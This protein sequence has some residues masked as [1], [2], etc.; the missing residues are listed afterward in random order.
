MKIKNK[1]KKVIKATGMP[2]HQ[3]TQLTDRQ[4]RAIFIDRK[5]TM[6]QLA[7]HY[8]VS[9]T[10]IS[11]I[12]N[13]KRRADVTVGLPVY[14]RENFRKK[15]SGGYKLTPQEAKNVLESPHTD[16]EVAEQYGVHVDTIKRIRSGE[17]YGAKVTRK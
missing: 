4:V 14:R 3:Y 8:K 13:G 11:L 5:S 17:T 1:P 10:L 2:D 12:K 15:N 16:E 9:S 7:D 6:Q